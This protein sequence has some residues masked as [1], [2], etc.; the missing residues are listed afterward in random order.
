MR[1]QLRLATA[2]SV[3][4]LYAVQGLAAALPGIQDHL[5]AGD[6]APGLLTAAYTL[7]AV[8]FALPFGY[9]ADAIGRRRV[10]VATAVLWSV[11]GGAQA[12]VDSLELMVALRF[13][14]G[15]GF[16]ALMPLTVTLIGDA[17]R[18]LHQVRAQASRQAA[19]TG[20][21]FLLPLVGGALA[22]VSWNAP[23]Y[24]QLAFLPLAF[25]GAAVLEDRPSAE[26]GVGRY[27]RELGGAMRIPGIG[28]LLAAGFLRFWCK[29]AVIVY[30]PFL[31]VR[32]HGA[33]PF[34]AALVISVGSLVAALAAMQVVRALRVAP[35]SRLIIASVVLV[36]AGMVGFA[37]APSW[38]V[39]LAVTV[40]YGVGDGCLAVLQN[41]VVTEAAPPALRAGVIAAN[42]TVRNFGKLAAPLAVGGLMLVAAPWLAVVAVGAVAFAAVPLLASLARLD[43]LVE[44]PRLTSS[45]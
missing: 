26:R 13:A 12:L 4:I 6:S 27:A 2:A 35:A 34:E 17:V 22:A 7:P 14:Q 33:T 25:A 11:A 5:G 32:T 39:A 24:A 36:G 42:G 37:V 31:L 1:G 18:G 9:L 38:Q 43:A 28:P 44:V 10:F 23:L 8:L 40:V 41:T 19:M 29:Y 16:A 45:A 21:E 15:V 30:V 3:G 20:G